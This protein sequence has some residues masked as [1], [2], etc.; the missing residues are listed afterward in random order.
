MDVEAEVV[1]EVA[2]EVETG[3][4]GARVAEEDEGFEEEEEAA[5]R[6]S[7]GGS[8]RGQRLDGCSSYRVGLEEVHTLG[9]A[10]MLVMSLA[11]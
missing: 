11:Y 10:W 9:V 2:E 4:R 3:G 8:W 6:N 5:L 7:G 1:E